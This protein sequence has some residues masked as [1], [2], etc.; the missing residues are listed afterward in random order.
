MNKRAIRA[1]VKTLSLEE[2]REEARRWRLLIHDAARE[3]HRSAGM[4]TG[5]GGRR[6]GKASVIALR[7]L[8]ER[9]RN[10][11]RRLRRRIDGRPTEDHKS[12]RMDATTM[13][14]RAIRA[15]VF[16]LSR[17]ELR[18]EARLWRELIDETPPEGHTSRSWADVRESVEHSKR[19]DERLDDADPGSAKYCEERLRNICILMRSRNDGRRP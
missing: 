10:D 18:E 11:L 12:A 17:E 14:R 1:R 4:T 6:T 7:L 9:I 3:G 16:A 8:L 5:P 15:S 2:L 19:L 13:T